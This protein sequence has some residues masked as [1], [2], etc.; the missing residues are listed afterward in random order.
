MLGGHGHSSSAMTRLRDRQ[1]STRARGFRSTFQTMGSCG[2]RDTATLPRCGCVEVALHL[3]HRLDV[4]EGGRRGEGEG[5]MGGG[6][7]CSAGSLQQVPRRRPGPAV[8]ASPPAASAG[9][10]ETRQ[11]AHARGQASPVLLRHRHSLPDLTHPPPPKGVRRALQRQPHFRMAS[12]CRPRPEVRNCNSHR[13][14]D[15]DSDSNPDPSRP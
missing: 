12:C 2:C 13:V 1:P 3:L 11:R 10:Q 15:P 7:K 14:P 8:A 5:R 9:R 4:D 6:G